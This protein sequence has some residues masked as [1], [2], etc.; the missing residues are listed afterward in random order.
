MRD[1]RS[2]KHRKR[3]NKHD[4][5]TSPIKRSRNQIRVILKDPRMIV[6]QIVLHEEA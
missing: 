1:T 2:P 3:Q 5:Q 6:P 4:G